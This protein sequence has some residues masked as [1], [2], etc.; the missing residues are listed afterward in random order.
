[1]QQ[2]GG[3][4][5][6]IASKLFWLVFAPSHFLALLTVAAA[7]LLQT[8]YDRIGRRLAAA[9]AVLFVVIGIFPTGIWLARPL[10]DR[11]TRPNWP[12]HVDGVLVLGG[13]LG[14][15]ILYSRRVPARAL[16]EARLVSAYE[17]ARRYPN[18]RIVFSSGSGSISDVFGDAPAAWYIFRQMGLNPKRLTLEGRSRN[19]WENIVFSR[20][21][22]QPR[23]GEVWVLATSA[24]HMPRAMRVAER[25][26][27]KM[28]PWP[29][30]YLTTP[31]GF[32]NVFTIPGN[33]EATDNAIHEWIG[34]L[35]YR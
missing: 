1:M 5:F 17:L 14:T 24:I 10:E 22:A 27:W 35:A 23:P 21:I 12:S 3:E 15:P 20:K 30:D 31:D 26:H 34:L 13:G 29:T 18:A 16:S 9:A 7:I 28:I 2:P 33:L 19:T 25:A 8:K 4:M 11:I 6:F 32:G